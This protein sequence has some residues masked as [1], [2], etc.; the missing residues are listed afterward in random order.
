MTRIFNDPR[1]FKDEMVDGYVAAYGR[2][3]RRVPNASG[4]MAAGAPFPGRVAVINGGG[5]GH[6]PAFC[7]LVG[8]GGMTASV[9]GDI[10][11]SPSGEHAYRVAKAVDGG[12]GVLFTYGTY[13]A[14]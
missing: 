6:Y 3:L 2:Y 14:T 9:I 7:G 10:F 5:S 13:A 12:A 1:S 8:E 11:T 4:V